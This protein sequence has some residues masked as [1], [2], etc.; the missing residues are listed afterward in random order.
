MLN[1]RSFA[2]TV[3]AGLL[4]QLGL[5]VGAIVLRRTGDCLDSDLVSRKLHKIQL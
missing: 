1:G 4:P 5:D 2:G 3:G